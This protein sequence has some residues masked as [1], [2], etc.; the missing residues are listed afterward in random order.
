MRKAQL[1][2]LLAVACGGM[3]DSQ[4]DSAATGGST[5]STR[6]ATA[7]STGIGG[8]SATGGELGVAGTAGSLDVMWVTGGNSS[9]NEAPSSCQCDALQSGVKSCTPNSTTSL[10][11]CAECLDGNTWCNAT[12]LTCSWVG[13]ASSCTCT[14]TGSDGSSTWV[15][16]YK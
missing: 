3:V 2:A 5:A 12:G 1:A 14:A 10:N 7:N 15:C 4:L 8:V 11:L 16:K 9:T 6:V 13:T